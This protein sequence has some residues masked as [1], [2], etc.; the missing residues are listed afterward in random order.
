MLPGGTDV[1]CHHIDAQHNAIAHV[2]HANHLGDGAPAIEVVGGFIAG[3]SPCQ[4]L[5]KIRLAHLIQFRAQHLLHLFP[6]HGLRLHTKPLFVGGIGELVDFIAVD[7]GDQDRK[8]VSD[9]AQTF[10][11]DRL[12][13]FAVFPLGNIHGHCV[14]PAD[15]APV[16]LFRNVDRR[17]VPSFAVDLH[18]V[19][20]RC[21]GAGHGTVDIGLD[22]EVLLL[23][24]ELRDLPAQ[25]LLFCFSV[26]A[27]SV[28]IEK[29]K[30]LVL[31]DMA[32][33][34]RQIFRDGE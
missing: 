12:P 2:R 7:V 33:Q 18:L 9:R 11:A 10:L 28:L 22:V 16:L 29:Q 5:Q 6:D 24:I 1:G 3:F 32:D 25:Q 15:S 17:E 13:Q 8:I 27:Q 34:G 26:K 23:A 31:V 30:F 20:E 21:L 4:V 14:K 19:F